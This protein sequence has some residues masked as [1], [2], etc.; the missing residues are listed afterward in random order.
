MSYIHRAP[1]R[2]LHITECINM[3]ELKVLSSLTEILQLFVTLAKNGDS[4]VKGQ[5]TK[6]ST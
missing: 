6:S 3:N 1:H 4:I 2:T 5:G